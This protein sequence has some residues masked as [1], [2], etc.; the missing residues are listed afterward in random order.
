MFIWCLKTVPV[1]SSKWSHLRVR[2]GGLGNLQGLKDSRQGFQIGQEK[3]GNF[4]DRGLVT[5][6]YWQVG[7]LG[8]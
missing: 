6:P 8:P 2:S 4:P 3:G 7:L 1:R 5:G